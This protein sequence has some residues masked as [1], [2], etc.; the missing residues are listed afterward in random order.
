MSVVQKVL[1]SIERNLNDDLSLD[2]LAQAAG[3]SRHHLVRAFGAATGV[4]PMTYVRR[5]RL[6]EAANALTNGATE[7]LP[8]ALDAKYESHEAFTR[9]FKDQ[10]GVTPAVARQ[11]GRESLKL[12]APFPFTP[13]AQSALKPP[14]MVTAGPLI[15]VGLVERQSLET[16]EAIPAQWRRF[17]QR[18]GEI[19]DR[20]EDIPV[21]VS[22][23]ADEDGAF[24]YACAVIVKRADRAPAGLKRIDLPK[25]SYA[26]FDHEDH[27][28]T[29]QST[30][31]AIW[32]QGVGGYDIADA[33]NLEKHKPSF[34][35]RTGL[36]GVEIWIAVE[37]RPS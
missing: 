29:I 36:G 3:V 22:F 10:F 37:R 21:G 9:A 25:Q 23:G 32:D 16:T 24:D 20:A 33:P 7:I 2:A 30:Y 34:D 18:Y 13:P 11:A 27:V 4:A 6:S 17:M 12:T 19:E 5:R 1:W 26:V 8:V 35:T 28:S 15:L 14:R 31:M